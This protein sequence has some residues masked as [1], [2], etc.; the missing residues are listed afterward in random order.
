M[1]R[2]LTWLGL[3]LVLA[4]CVDEQAAQHKLARER[5]HAGLAQIRQAETGYV[6]EGRETRVEHEIE[7]EL[8]EIEQADH[9]AY[10]QSALDQATHDLES[11]I[12]DGPE[13]Q[14]AA[15][16]R[17]LA[18]LYVSSARKLHQD[19][20]TRWAGM[21]NGVATMQSYIVAVD[22]ADSRART[23]DGDGQELLNQLNDDIDTAS[24]TVLSMEQQA[25]ELASKIEALGRQAGDFKGRSEKHL[26]SAQ[27]LQA[28]ALKSVGDEK[29]ELYTL[30]DSDKRQAFVALAEAQGVEAQLDVI[31][32]R[33]KVM[34]AELDLAREGH[35][36]LEQQAHD[37][38]TRVEQS[39]DLADQALA[40][41][42]EALQRMHD[43]FEYLNAV[44]RDEVDGPLAESQG[45]VSDAVRLAGEAV[46]KVRGRDQKAVKLDLLAARVE[47]A[48]VMSSR[49]LVSHGYG[50]KLGVVRLVGQRTAEAE[51]VAVIDAAKQ[52]EQ[53]YTA[54][55]QEAVEAI[56]EA[57]SLASEISELSTEGEY[58]GLIADQQAERLDNYRQR[59]PGGE[60]AEL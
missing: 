40:Q 10:R 12:N 59:L 6:P 57:A 46:S 17:V 11:I 60:E 53:E 33:L 4:A 52:L 13:S 34:Q 20:M 44:Y 2:S 37:T 50:Q 19:A 3:A 47:L 7:G 55:R 5:F 15:V 31:S 18:D 51:T 36:F 21:S 48:N 43:L 9:Q 28:E 41:K 42:S 23:L 45:L 32:S 56:E 35:L 49:V 8:V 22:G 24:D 1:K 30:A 16:R 38:R 14:Q 58:V 27:A 25:A 39:R 54:L 26:T 29:Y